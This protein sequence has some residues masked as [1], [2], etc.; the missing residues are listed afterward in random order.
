[1][2]IAQA[3]KMSCKRAKSCRE[4]PDDVTGICLE[5][6]ADSIT[7]WCTMQLVNKQFRR[8]ARK[9]RS[10]AHIWLSIRPAFLDKVG[11]GLRSLRI[12]DD[13]RNQHEVSRLAQMSSLT[14]LDC[15]SLELGNSVVAAISNL[16]SLTSLNLTNADLSGE[17]ISGFS[18]LTRMRDLT[19]TGAAMYLGIGERMKTGL[20]FLRTMNQLHTL[21]L[22]LTE[23]TNA[24]LRDVAFLCEL[25]MLTL[26]DC[27]QLTEAGLGALAPLTKLEVLRL[28]FDLTD[29]GLVAIATLVSLR[30]LPLSKQVTNAGLWAIAN[31]K[32]LH[33]LDLSE[34]PITD[35]AMPALRDMYLLRSLDLSST[36]ITDVGL[37]ACGPLP[38]LE[39]LDVSGCSAIVGHGL[40]S[41]CKLQH[42]DVGYCAKLKVVPHMAFK[43]LNMKASQSVRVEGLCA[44]PLVD[45]DWS[46]GHRELP[47][48]MAVGSLDR[49]EILN[50]SYSGATDAGLFA[51]R[52]L[53]HL[54]SLDLSMCPDL[55]DRGVSQLSTLTALQKLNLSE[56][57]I[58]GEH[59][60]DLAH[61]PLRILELSR[62][63]V[64]R[65]GVR[66]A[67]F[68][69][70]L[71][72]LDLEGIL[73][74]KQNV[75]DLAKLPHLRWLNLLMCGFA[76]DRAMFPGV[77]VRLQIEDARSWFRSQTE[78]MSLV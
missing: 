40:K 32:Q 2:L 54:K 59:L 53:K 7:I 24:G 78:R 71:T 70:S 3:K 66:A 13:F 62:G 22:G 34:C 37:E 29:L 10:L 73:L 1:M 52:A 48:L 68:L 77:T 74:S 49:L 16:T 12:T 43:K 6:S 60:S 72:Y 55:T 14:V 9:P 4:L 26:T 25:R 18:K 31:F 11:F 51:L 28:P 27:A 69:T 21:H 46:W 47:D 15:S 44:M 30:Q 33:T 64:T 65:E 19:L 17:I 45:L 5:F 50:L 20:E 39:D 63:R 58:T 8:C 41:F 61:L 36:R 23:V 67:S 75:K 42:L 56:C 57:R 35:E 38:L 76:C